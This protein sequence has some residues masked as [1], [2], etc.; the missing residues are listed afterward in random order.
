MSA[1]DAYLRELEGALR[2]RGRTRRR[3]LREC[4]DHLLDAA[5]ERGQAEAVRAF[6]PAADIAAELDGAVATRRGLRS[7]VVTVAAVSATAISTL[8]LIHSSSPGTDAPALWAIAFFV[9]A[10][11]AGVAGA[12]GAVQA[13]AARRAA[14]P[15]ADVA[16]LARRNTC[17]LVA[18]GA[19]LFSAGAALPGHGS[20]M[21]LL[22]GPA[23]LCVALVSVLRARSLA[24]RIGGSGPSPIRSPLADLAALTRL[25]IPP[26]DAARLLPI[27]TCLAAAAAFARDRAEHAT[28]GGA[29]ATA[30]IEAAAVVACFAALGPRLGLWRRASSVDTSSWNKP[31]K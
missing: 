12:L 9:A 24:R 11:V 30:S 22:A 10:Q 19:T 3:F 17:A 8:A 7:T 2:V 29:L 6:G 20:A 16:L 26:V 27:V 15:P 4:R 14:M 28:V 1:I 25:R 13:L 18:A 21:V 31:A 23:L 5:A